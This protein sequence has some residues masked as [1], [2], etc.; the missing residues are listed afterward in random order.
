MKNCFTYLRS[1]MLN[2]PEDPN[3]GLIIRSEKEG[4]VQCQ[5]TKAVYVFKVGLPDGGAYHG[6]VVEKK[7]PH[8]IPLT[9]KH[10]ERTGRDI[11]E[12]PLRD[13]KPHSS[14]AEIRFYRPGKE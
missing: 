11:E 2:Q 12:V 7:D 10:R 9:V 5:P 3:G 6:A 8:G 13:L 1:R 4:L 14:H